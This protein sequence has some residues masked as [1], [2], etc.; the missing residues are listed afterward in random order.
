[1]RRNPLLGTTTPRYGA[2][3]CWLVVILSLAGCVSDAAPPCPARL[4]VP[5]ARVLDEH[6]AAQQH[7]VDAQL[8]DGATVFFGDSITEAL[9]A[10]GVVPGAV[11]Y[12]I[13]GNT[14][15]NLLARL[16]GYRSLPRARRVVVAIGINDVM[17]GSAAADVVA[18]VARVMDAVPQGPDI[19]IVG[20]LPINEAKRGEGRMRTVGEVNRGLRALAAECGRCR[21][22]DP[23][24]MALGGELAPAFDSGDGLHLSP[25]GYAAFAGVLRAGLA[26]EA[27]ARSM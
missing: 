19:A 3:F 9:Y 4:P 16:P 6:L 15:A 1:M 17:R 27:I 25:A 2:V 13:G 8:P 7:V 10:P 11:N 20:L 12:G 14:T 5:I 23:S 22:V 26:D 18:G 21:F 24:G